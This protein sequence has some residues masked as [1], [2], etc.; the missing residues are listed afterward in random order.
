[1]N[2][3]EI[4]LEVIK[5]LLM[6]Q[7]LANVRGSLSDVLAQKADPLVDYIMKEPVKS[8]DKRKP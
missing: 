1:M 5:T 4:K 2:R 8:S 7:S 6:S 3:Q